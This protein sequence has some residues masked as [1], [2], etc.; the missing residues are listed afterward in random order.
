MHALLMLLGR[1]ALILRVCFLSLIG[2]ACLFKGPDRPPRLNF[3]K[4]VDY[5]AWYNGFVSKD[6]SD[7]AE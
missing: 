2:C 5:V 3:D 6:K 7:N 1:C 4:P